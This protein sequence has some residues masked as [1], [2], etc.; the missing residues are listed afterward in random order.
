MMGENEADRRGDYITAVLR[1]YLEMPET[2]SKA[3]PSDRERAAEL[4]DRRIPI[5]LV[6]SAFLLASLRRLARS[7][8]SPRLSPIRSLA[9]FMPV[10]E[11]LQTNPLP[12]DYVDYVR[13]K[14]RK[15][16][17]DNLKSRQTSACSKKY[18]LS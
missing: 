1:L 18:V 14:V 15:L 16:A 9:Y 7:P 13:D 5:A 4:H 6:E 17:A 8:D 2:P 10:I 11:E 12:M 3:G